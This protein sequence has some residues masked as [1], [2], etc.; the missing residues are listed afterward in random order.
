[1]AKSKGFTAVIGE[2]LEKPIL[3]EISKKVHEQR[4]YERIGEI[5]H[6]DGKIWGL[7][8]KVLT[9]SIS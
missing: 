3:N 2:I 8:K 7:Y 9:S 6:S 1:L 5:K 4:G